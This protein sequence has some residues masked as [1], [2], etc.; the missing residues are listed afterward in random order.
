MGIGKYVFTLKITSFQRIYRREM[1][2]VLFNLILT[3]CKKSFTFKQLSMRSLM[4]ARSFN[5][6]KKDL[7]FPN[8]LYGEVEE[9]IENESKKMGSFTIDLNDV[10]NKLSIAEKSS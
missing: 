9:V 8:L 5:F 6:R 10:Y 7:K 4:E 2:N 3:L 1:K